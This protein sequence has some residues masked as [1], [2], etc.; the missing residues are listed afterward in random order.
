M[1]GEYQAGRE[2]II[3]DVKGAGMIVVN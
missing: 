1:V 2:K 3:F